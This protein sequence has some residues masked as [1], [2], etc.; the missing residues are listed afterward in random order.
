[1]RYGGHSGDNFNYRVYGKYFNRDD[2]FHANNNDFDAWQM[3]QSGFRTD[4]DL[5]P[6]DHLTIQGDLYKGE[7]GS[8]LTNAQY[9]PPYSQTLQQNADVFGANLLGRWKHTVG[10]ENGHVAAMVL[11]PHRPN[12]ADLAQQ[13]LSLNC[14][15]RRISIFSIASRWL[16]HQELTWGFEY[17]ATSDRIDSIPTIVFDP[18]D[19]DD[20]LATAFI[21]D[22]VAIVPDRPAS[23]DL[24]N[25][26][27]AQRFQRLGRGTL[28][29]SRL[30]ADREANRLDGHFARRPQLLRKW[31]KT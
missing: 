28:G 22:Q 20:N 17:R 18:N 13:S 3:G 21:Q 30:D 31:T 5:N 10:F 29:T 8:E 25:E 14:G 4:S 16:G 19:R 1:M 26:S 11:R 12:R 23:A 15:I 9:A 27:R 7:T 6:Q 24:R 2:S